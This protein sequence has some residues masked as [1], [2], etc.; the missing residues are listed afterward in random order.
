MKNNQT[1]HF[2]GVGMTKEDEKFN[3]D[4]GYYNGFDVADVMPE[5]DEE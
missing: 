2:D 3:D 1:K 4:H 5:V